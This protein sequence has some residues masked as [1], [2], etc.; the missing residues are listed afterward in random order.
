[1]ATVIPTGS[2]PAKGIHKM[3]WVLTGTDDGRP[4]VA[5]Q[6]PNKSV[7]VTGTFGGGTVLIEGSNDG[8]TTWSTLTDPQGNALSFTVTGAIE[9]VQEN[10]QLIRPRASVGVTSVTVNL[11]S[12]SGS[13]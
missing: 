7:Q 4:E 9:K 11:V 8:G 5:P 12:E 3:V 6:Y 13:R 1:M 2:S 10:T